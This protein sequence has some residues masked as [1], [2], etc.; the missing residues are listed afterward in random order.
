MLAASATA[1]PT[2]RAALIRRSLGVADDVCDT[3]TRTWTKCFRDVPQQD[4]NVDCGVFCLQF[5]QLA[6]A[7]QPGGFTF[8]QADINAM[9]EDL[10]LAMLQSPD[11]HIGA[12]DGSAVRRNPPA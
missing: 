8:G 6:G 4:G 3:E 5:A 7:G 1:L 9:R 10:T 2:L 11:E 12:E